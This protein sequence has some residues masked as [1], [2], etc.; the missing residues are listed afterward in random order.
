LDLK[1]DS[2]NLADQRE[3]EP[4]LATEKKVTVLLPDPRDLPLEF[5]RCPCPRAPAQQSPPPAAV[6]D[7]DMLPAAV[8]VLA[9]WKAR[10]HH[11]PADAATGRPAGLPHLAKMARQ[12]L[13]RPAPRPV[14]KA[15]SP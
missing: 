4:R 11:M 15:S 6:D 3:F 1:P 2:T 5:L 13:G 10:D 14:L 8:D 9:W 12:Y 7:L